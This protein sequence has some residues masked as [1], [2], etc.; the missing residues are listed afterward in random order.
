MDGNDT[1]YGGNE[2]DLLIGGLGVDRLLGGSDSDILIGGITIYD[3]DAAALNAPLS[4]WSSA[5]PYATRIQTIEDELFAVRIE[6]EETV[7]DDQVADELFGDDGED[8]FIQ[9][10]FM[11]VYSPVGGEAGGNDHASFVSN[12]LPELEGFDL[13]DSLDKMSDRLTTEA[14]HSKLPH[15]TSGVRQLEHLALFELARY[16]QVTHYA[17]TSGAWSNPATWHDGVVPGDGARVLIPIGV[18]VTVDG[19]IPT[20]LATIRLD[21]TLS[22]AATTDTELRVDTI[23]GSGSSR[24]EMGT[25]EQP[26]PA[27]ITARLLITDNGPIDRT[28]DPFGIS[29]G[30]ITHGS[31]VMHGAERTSHAAVQGSV[32][33]G[34]SM[35]VLE[36]IPVGWNIGDSVVLAS[37]TEG[38]EQNEVREIVAIF[39]AIIVLGQPLSYDHV[40]PAAGLQVH[41]ANL[42]RNVAIESEG[43]SIERRGHVMFMHNR[44]VEIANAGFYHLGRTNKLLPINDS[45]VDANWN[46]QPGTGTNQRAR[47]AVHFHRNGLVNDGNPSVVRGS[48]VVDAPGWGYVNHSSYV[49][50][51]DNLAFDVKGAAFSTEVGDEIGSFDGN[52]AIGTIGSGDSTESRTVLQDFG[53]EGDGFWL[54]GAG[55][56]VTNNIAAGNQG[57]AFA[58]YTRG[59]IEGGVQGQFLSANLPDPSLAGG[60]E[61]IAV[62]KVPVSDFRNNVGYASAIGLSVWFQLQS[63]AHQQQA[64]FEDSQFW[65]N[66]TGVYVPYTRQTVLRNL[67]VIHSPDVMPPVGV[68]MNI[69]TRDITY[70]NL[71]V[72]GYDRGIEVARSGYALVQGG[73]FDN[74]IDILV[75]TGVS[76]TRSVL[77]TGFAGLPRVVM[78][79]AFD[80]ISGSVA[81]IFLQDTVVIDYGP[82]VNQRL[83]Y[84]W[85]RAGAVPFPEPRVGL[86]AEYVGLTTQQLWDQY[87][88]AVGGE[89]A[90]SDVIEVPSITGLIGPPI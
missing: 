64:V 80:P 41:V 32:S 27:G 79:S 78:G 25:S 75:Q 34:T 7:F 67:S 57:S 15:A 83:Y 49:D 76:S 35:L 10:G 59:L 60:A 30:L 65:N 89:I 37:T 72:T 39:G 58:F 52:I 50:M 62:G 56:S 47:Y 1:I 71:T 90:P 51:L 26:I 45:V 5:A 63:A 73:N 12:E 40:P 44:D 6:S 2:R 82:F 38:T 11:G 70:D 85:Q 53:H 36:N 22:F 54:Q 69:V 3:D 48:V 29:R 86:P 4:V 66:T 43:L 55:V 68:G 88:I 33:A 9:T 81:H 31:V 16:D 17:V 13:I 77:L 46:L 14:I 18:E 84:R 24:F 42:T 61:T 20:R 19:V 74:H 21:G 87:G 8:W 28:W 23:I